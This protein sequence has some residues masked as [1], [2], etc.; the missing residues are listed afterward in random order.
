MK[1]PKPALAKAG[2]NG[3]EPYAYLRHVFTELL[4][5]Q[6]FPDVEALLPT[7]LG[8]AALARNSF[9]DVSFSARQ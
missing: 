6:S 5:A 8:P 1:P 2:A 7:R 9:Q 3:L 4:K